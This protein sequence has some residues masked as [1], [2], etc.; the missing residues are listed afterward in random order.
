MSLIP[1][2]D[3]HN[4]FLLRLLKNPA[5]RDAIW[6]MGDGTGHLDLPRMRK[7]GFAGG[8]FAIYIPSPHDDPAGALDADMDTP[9]YD[10]PLPPALF[11]LGRQTADG[12]RVDGEPLLLKDGAVVQVAQ[13][14]ASVR[15]KPIQSVAI[16]RNQ[17]QSVAIRRNPSQSVAIRTY[18][19]LS[20]VG[21]VVPGQE[22]HGIPSS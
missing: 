6:T 3:G 5:E 20:K 4:D 9:P 12:P 1:V 7:G 13:R 11:T 8:M 21:A 17:S 14:A 16:N 19:L 22:E 18:R 15:G 2:F 10:L